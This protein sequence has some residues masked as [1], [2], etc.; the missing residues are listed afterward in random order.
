MVIE[1]QHQSFPFISNEKGSISLYIFF[2]SQLLSLLFILIT[3]AYQSEKKFIHLEREHQDH[4][5]IHQMTYQNSIDT[6]SSQPIPSTGNY[7]FP[8]GTAKYTFY[9]EDE[10]WT[11]NIVSQT[12]PP[13]QLSLNYPLVIEKESIP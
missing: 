4:M 2:V 1:L 11:L 13:Y 7:Q 6:W 5:M 10:Q 12:S 3:L 9:L 8:I